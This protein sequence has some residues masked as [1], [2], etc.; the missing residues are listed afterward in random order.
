MGYREAWMEIGVVG[1]GYVGTVLAVGLASLGNQ[2]TVIERDDE[3]LHM[4]QAGTP[5]FYEEGLP[6]LLAN[7]L[8][9]GT[10]DFSRSISAV[11]AC[12]IVFLCVG[13]P[14]G[15][16]GRPDMAAVDAVIDEL[17][18]NADGDTVLVLK[19]TVPIGTA[20]KLSAELEFRTAENHNANLTVVS[21]PEF[22]REGNAVEDFFHPARIVLGGKSAQAIEAVEELY[23][24]LI[25]GEFEAGGADARPGVIKTDH[26]T[27]EMIKYASNAFLAGK[28][29]F[30]NEIARLSDGVGSDVRVI[31]EALGLDPRIGRPFLDAGV[32]WGGSCFGKDID[33]L[34]TIAGDINVDVPLLKAVTDVNQMQRS[35]VVDRLRQELGYLEARR[36]AILGVAFKPGT[37]DTRDSPGLAIATELLDAGAIVVA[38]DP[39]VKH[40]DGQKGLRFADDPY[41]ASADADAVVLVTDWPDFTS[42]DATELA[43][44]MAGSLVYDGRNV[45]DSSAYVS[46]GLTYVGIGRP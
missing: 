21:N 26:A 8:A 45:L 41:S 36:I 40:V 16:T 33:A 39:L 4:L 24:P 9:E 34:I 3:R 35:A 27:A 10:I 44:V 12:D 43:Q 2:V 37:D 31:S 30:I 22:L 29:S 11:A 13:T 20:E 1:G 38:Y 14:P 19:S 5:F 18:T 25:V 28:I 6:E 23:R 42:I 7:V 17:I 32:G 46:A 15:P